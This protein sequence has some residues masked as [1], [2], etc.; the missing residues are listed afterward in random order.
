MG[1]QGVV[2]FLSRNLKSSNMAME[3]SPLRMK[4]KSLSS[5]LLSG[6]NAALRAREMI[7]DVR[8]RPL[9]KLYISSGR[10]REIDRCLGRAEVA[11]SKKHFSRAMKYWARVTENALDALRYARS[12]VFGG[13]Q[14]SRD[15]LAKVEE[16]AVLVEGYA[17]TTTP[18]PE[19][20]DDKHYRAQ[21]PGLGQLC[22]EECWAHY[23][24]K[25]WRKGLNPNPLFDSAWYAAQRSKH[26]AEPALPSGHEVPV[27]TH[28]LAA[29]PRPPSAEGYVYVFTSICLNYVSKARVLAATMKKHNPS[30]RFC[31]LINEPIPQSL[32]GVEGA[33]DE[34][35]TCEQLGIENFASWTF[36]HTVVEF[37]TAVKAFMLLELL[38]RKDCRMAFYFDPDI[39]VF[40]SITPLIDELEETSIVL[41]P[42]LTAPEREFEAVMDNEVCALQHGIYN[43]GFIGVRP[44]TQ[45]LAF[46]NWWR[47]RLRVL[48]RADIPSGLFTDQRWIDFVPAF[49]SEHAIIRHP[50]C[51]VATWNLSNR[52]IKG[53]MD[54]GFTVNGEPLIFYHFSGLD[55]GSQ[56][57]MLGKYGRDMAAAHEL[58][59]WYIDA[60]RETDDLTSSLSW[61][62]SSYSD[63]T[64]ITDKQRRLYR[65]RAD[66][67][68]H[69]PSPFECEDA[70]RSY[71]HWYLAQGFD[72]GSKKPAVDESDLEHYLRV[73]ARLG[74][75]P[76]AMFDGNWYVKNYPDALSS[77]TSPLGHYVRRGMGQGL[78]PCADFDVKWYAD[79][80]S[81]RDCSRWAL[82]HYMNVGRAAG[83]RTNPRYDAVRDI[84]ARGTLVR[85]A[86][87]GP[88]LILVVQHFG[89]GGTARHVSDLAA[90]C[91][92]RARMLV[93]SPMKNGCVRFHPH[94][95]GLDDE[96]CFDPK[97][98]FAD[99]VAFLHDCSPDR[100]HVQHVMGNELFLKS[101][102]QELALPFDFT[103]HDYYI[104]SPSAA[105]VGA[106]GRFVGEDLHAH[107]AALVK[108]PSGNVKVQSLAVWQDS[109]RWIAEHAE[110][111]I[112]P[113]V[114]TARR[115]GSHFPSLNI[116]AAAHPDKKVKDVPVQA[117]ELLAPEARLRVV[118]IG[119]LL[120]HK[121]YDVLRRTAELARKHGAPVIFEVIGA[122][123]GQRELD[124]LEAARV[125]VW[126]AYEEVM[127]PKCIEKSRP[128]LLWFP[129]QC[130]E[131]YSYT[132]SS[133]LEA[134]LPVVAP[135][136][137]AFPERLSG[138]SWTWIRPW[139][140]D[141][142]EWLGFFKDIRL[143]N[144]CTGTEPPVLPALTQAVTDYYEFE[145]LRPLITASPSQS[146]RG[147]SRTVEGFGVVDSL[148]V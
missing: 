1:L 62:Y 113:S 75:N 100:V 81:A 73:G 143:A 146:G 61:R 121:G 35:I 135:R 84:D 3:K 57:A 78:A 117:P 91:E 116:T 136:L 115:F 31:L 89:G 36:R 11:N 66:L 54:H 144:F 85:W 28:T 119:D 148:Q 8:Q 90:L 141:P 21:S 4:E 114:D 74:L 108:N 45:G 52:S 96:L 109:H 134:G 22:R 105:L 122:P 147:S 103:V 82:L 130:P 60:S 120:L 127:L 17:A 26:F 34:V 12:K 111:V 30:I 133:A 29:A 132:L 83:A 25:G 106:D 47:D 92:N 118:Y 107:E 98:Q 7:V 125:K 72:E 124:Q 23:R 37:S 40:A 56:E 140:L 126:G 123:I 24:S 38:N 142:V 15:V 97:T 129:A 13:L 16:L 138:R 68:T 88:P 6:R 9:G 104:L 137:G 32:S 53:G 69:F 95:A 76:N 2:D 41:T 20:F 102:L 65:D 39:A 131:T 5:K 64:R 63:G 50:G 27:T 145:Y 101:L 18:V 58:R 55:S 87:E 93:L 19:L 70:A 67:Q 48:C 86:S 128:H 10:L 112:A 71:L 110:R 44:T 43:L 49:F 59:R 77:G 42:H 94:A 51:N 99:M 79:Q 80:Y 139:N 14:V 46:A 33:F